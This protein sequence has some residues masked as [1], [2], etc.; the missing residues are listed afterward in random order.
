MVTDGARRARLA[1]TGPMARLTFEALERLAT[2]QVAETLLQSALDAAQ[3]DTVPEDAPGFGS[4]ACGA[5]KIVVREALGAE[6]SD[7]VMSDLEPAFV[8]GGRLPGSGVRKRGRESLTTPQAHE[9]VVLIA[10]ED[11]AIVERLLPSFDETTK[12]VAAYDVFGLLQS[13][14]RY[15]DHP[16]ILILHDEMQ[17]IRPSSLATL[18]RVMPATTT[19]LQFGKRGTEPER[20]AELPELRWVRLGDVAAHEVL[21]ACAE[22]LQPTVALPEPANAKRIL[23]AHGDSTRRGELAARL[24]HAGHEVLEAN[25]GVRALDICVNQGPEM[26]LL[27]SALPNL[28]GLQLSAVIEMRFG[29]DAPPVHLLGTPSDPDLGLPTVPETDVEAVLA[30]A[31]D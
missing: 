4:F 21:E 15:I 31:Q 2:P 14:Q 25:D 26:V 30:L 18:A 8:K 3:L 22:L 11:R 7:A 6:S 27:Q 20:R 28:D 9:R 24:R 19:I 23:L 29:S 1:K 10:S 12:V 16:M 5:L 13:S 17:S